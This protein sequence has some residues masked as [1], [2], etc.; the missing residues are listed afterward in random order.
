MSPFTKGAG[1]ASALMGAIQMGI[2]ACVSTVV[3]MIQSGS[4]MPMAIVMS[5]CSIIALLVLLTGSRVIRYRVNAVAE[6]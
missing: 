5:A 6:A 1:S 4:L 3:S 2:G